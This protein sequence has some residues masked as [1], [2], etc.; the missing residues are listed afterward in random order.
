MTHHHHESESG[1]LDRRLWASAALNLGITLV[2][3]VGGLWAGSLALL[4]DAARG[5]GIQAPPLGFAAGLPASMRPRPRGRGIVPG[6][7]EHP[8]CPRC[9]NEATTARSWTSHRDAHGLQLRT[10]F[11]EATTARSWNSD[12]S[13][14]R[15]GR[16]ICFN[17]A[18]TAR[19]WNS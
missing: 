6:S 7:P 11:N 9:F 16:R 14:A 19:S 4:A 1:N 5:R 3:L 15:R 2:E 18:T 13:F 10:R 17:E 8:R 12:R